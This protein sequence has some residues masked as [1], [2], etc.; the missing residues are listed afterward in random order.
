MST[1]VHLGKGAAL[2]IALVVLNV[3][4]TF[5]NVWPTLGVRVPWAISLEAVACVLLLAGLRAR[6]VSPGR[7]SLRW[8]AATWVMLVIVRYAAITTRSLYGRDINLYW[9]LRNIP[10]V[11]AMLA[12]VAKP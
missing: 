8:L 1:W 10:D 5:V 7:R 3:S 6:G 9:D 2:A 12:F 4:L 11:G